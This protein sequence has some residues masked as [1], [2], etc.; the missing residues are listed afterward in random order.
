[1]ILESVDDK[2]SFHHL[3]QMKMQLIL[4]SETFPQG[5]KKKVKKTKTEKYWDWELTNETK[6]IWV[7][8][9]F[10]FS[11]VFCDLHLA[12]Y[13]CALCLPF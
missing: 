1:M 10:N 13:M 7:S 4:H 2:L 3:M 9:T 12:P 5:E 11:H 8:L 6:P